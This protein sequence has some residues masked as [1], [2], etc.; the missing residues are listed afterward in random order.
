MQESKEKNV[1]AERTVRISGSN[2]SKI[3]LRSLRYAKMW[4]ILINKRLNKRLRVCFEI[5]FSK[6]TKKCLSRYYE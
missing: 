3:N 1:R 2:K 5:F 4:L 6:K